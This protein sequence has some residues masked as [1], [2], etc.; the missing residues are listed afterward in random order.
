MTA[1]D[2]GEKG[3]EAPTSS[4][5][6][7]ENDSVES[8]LAAAIAEVEA[9]HSDPAVEETAAE[10]RA[11]D[12]KGRFANKEAAQAAPQTAPTEQPQQPQPSQFSPIQ[13]WN[14]EQRA[15]FAALPPEA[16][17]IVHDRALQV[18]QHFS[19]TSQQL[20]A[21]A[22]DYRDLD[23]TLQPYA[24]KWQ[25]EGV[26]RSQVVG[27]LLAAQDFINSDPVGAIQWIASTTGVDLSRIGQAQPQVDPQI[28]TMQQQL[29]A[30]QAHIEQQN[31]FAQQ[32]V[33]HSAQ[34]EIESFASETDANGQPLRP[35][36]NEIYQE[37]A[38]IVHLLRSQNPNAPHRAILQEAYD[39]ASWTNPNVRQQLIQS[40]QAAAE[41]KRTADERAKA[42]QAKKA[43][44]SLSG[45]PNGTG[46]IDFG[47]SVESA[48][49]A[50]IQLHS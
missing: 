33:L 26:S 27:Q 25:L 45:A 14:A 17:K 43:G 49:R 41:A 48:L 24:Q 10:A 12:E 50:A 16:Q 6:E 37:M 32:Q 38:P 35:H 39:R 7:I 31:A 3:L 30:M 8:A 23:Q 15:A 36:Y 1:M 20:Q 13:S 44:V 42:Q 22:A 5:T 2:G 34:S 40:Q 46:S 18:E 21:V 29:Q 47:D 28:M 4:E 9:K 19:R 11:R